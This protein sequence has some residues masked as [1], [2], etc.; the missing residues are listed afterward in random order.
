MSTSPPWRY[1]VLPGNESCLMREALQR[2]P[3]WQPAA[4]AEPDTDSNTAC[5]SSRSCDYNLWYGGNG[6]RFNWEQHKPF[7]QPGGWQGARRCW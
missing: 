7:M 2:R 5:S 6:Q 4:D 3:H 1:L